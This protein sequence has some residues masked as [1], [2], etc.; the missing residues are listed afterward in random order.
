[1]SE[2]YRRQIEDAVLAVRREEGRNKPFPDKYAKERIDW[3]LGHN[4]VESQKREGS[5]PVSDD[6]FKLYNWASREY[7]LEL[8]RK[9]R[10]QDAKQEHESRQKSSP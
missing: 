6:L 7:F 4:F 9:L 3:H 5:E 10:Y 2:N 1:M 8:L